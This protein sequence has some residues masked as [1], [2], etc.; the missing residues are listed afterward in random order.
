MKKI[1]KK[2]ILFSLEMLEIEKGDI[3]LVHSALTSIG[4]VEGGADTVVDA[5]LEAVGPTG[6]LIMSTLTGWDAPFDPENTPSSVGIITEV[7]RKR[8]GVLRSLH[9]VHSVAAYGKN[10]AYIVSHHED[11]ATGCGDG[12]PYRKIAELDGKVMLLGV[13]MDRCTVMHTLEESA[14]LAYLFSLDI[15]APKYPPYHGKGTFTLKKFPPGHRDFL[16]ITPVLKRRGELLEGKMGNAVCRVM[17]ARSMFDTI[18]PMLWEN[19]LL[20]MCENENCNFCCWAHSIYDPRIRANFDHFAQNHC[21]DPTCEICVIPECA[22]KE[23]DELKTS[24][25]TGGGV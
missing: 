17:K 13:D 9:P 8:P 22:R 19:P 3:L 10:A 25:L 23:K 5:L 2:D 12:T 21:N 18:L 15:P 7:F 6:T 4:H 24:V 11:C 20:F 1:E 14:D 16:C